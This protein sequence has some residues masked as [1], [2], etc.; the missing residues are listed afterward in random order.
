MMRSCDSAGPLQ[1]ARIYPAPIATRFHSAG[2][3]LSL[4]GCQAKV[5][6]ISVCGAGVSV[7]AEL[8]LFR[9]LAAGVYEPSFV[10]HRPNMDHA[11]P[12][13]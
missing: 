11:G 4:M 1:G 6:L 9:A 7:A 5:Q 2:P 8:P 10:F 13:F 12:D 3:D